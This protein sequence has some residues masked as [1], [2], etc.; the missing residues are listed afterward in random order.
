[1][2]Y[3][4]STRLIIL[5]CLRNAVFIFSLVGG[6]FGMLG[7]WI[8]GDFSLQWALIPSSIVFL[9][10]SYLIFRRKNT[11]ITINP[12]TK[13]LE[14]TNN[15]GVRQWDIPQHTFEPHIAVNTLNG[16]PVS[17]I[18]QIIID[19]E[20][21]ETCHYMNEHTFNKLIAILQDLMKISGQKPENDLHSAK[22]TY[23][24]NK[25][26]LIPRVQGRLIALSGM[27]VIALITPFIWKIYN[28]DPVGIIFMNTIAYM[29][30]VM[31]GIPLIIVFRLV[32]KNKKHIP[33]T[34]TIAPKELI[35]DDLHIPLTDII[36][37]DMFQPGNAGK[38]MN[39]CT[40]KITARDGRKYKFCT[41]FGDDYLNTSGTK[42]I[43]PQY[44]EFVATLSEICAATPGKLVLRL[45]NA[46]Y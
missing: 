29:S 17:Y 5:K 37:I 27:F 44:A 43:F 22:T 35:F 25:K 4:S 45:G 38:F 19:D 39:L 12:E 46:Q 1:M 13:I 40:M 11:T 41:G 26:A 33:N 9:I 42:T 31:I 2:Q 32:N 8:T 3:K 21:A 23:T 18:R 15:H 24:L 7:V 34:I 14:V 16:T 20:Y 6:A 10:N 28:P 30:A 36:N